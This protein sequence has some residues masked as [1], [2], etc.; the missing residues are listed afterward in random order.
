[1]HAFPTGHFTYNSVGTIQ[2]TVRRFSNSLPIAV[3]FNL[4]A[5]QQ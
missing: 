5:A 2:R 3:Q 4:E 1:L